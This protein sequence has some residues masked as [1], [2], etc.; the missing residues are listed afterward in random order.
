M[1]SCILL[2]AYLMCVCSPPPPPPARAHVPG[3]LGTIIHLFLMYLLQHRTVIPREQ[4]LELLYPN[5]LSTN[6]HHFQVHNP[7]HFL[8]TAAQPVKTPP[9][10]VGESGVCRPDKGSYM[11]WKH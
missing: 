2:S 5:S 6:T 8:I 10:R 4:A 9:E 1:L 11:Q 3:G 7:P